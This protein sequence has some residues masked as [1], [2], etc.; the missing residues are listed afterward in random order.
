[1]NIKDVFII[2][3]ARMS[4]SRF[5]GKMMARLGDIP[6]IDFIYKRCCESSIKNILVATSDHKSDD[7]L[8]NHCRGRGIP[9][10]RGNLHNVLKRYIQ[11]GELLNARYIIRV[12]G[13]T[14]FV[15][16]SLADSPIRYAY[17]R[18]ARLCSS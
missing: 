12:C 18:R 7:I 11:A 8:Y 1:M 4:S 9:I 2:I 13:D 10:M 3:Q 17:Q 14:P 15:D 5:P 16:I 6:L